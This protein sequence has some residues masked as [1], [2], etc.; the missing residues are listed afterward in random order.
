V[1]GAFCPDWILLPVFFR[2]ELSAIPRL[3]ESR[4][5]PIAGL[6]L[7]ILILGCAA[8]PAHPEIRLE[9]NAFVDTA[10]RK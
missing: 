8:S 2:L 1:G 7:S 4:I 9:R 10:A 3:V 6:A 5:P